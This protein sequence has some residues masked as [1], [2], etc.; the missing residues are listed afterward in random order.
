[1]WN[2]G[3]SGSIGP[4]LRPEAAASLPPGTGIGDYGEIVIGQDL[5]FAWHRFQLWAEVF[6]S[7]F[8][9]PNVGD[10]DLL[11]YYVEAKYKLTSQLFFAARWNQQLYGSVPDDEKEVQWGNNAARIDAVVGYRFSRYLQLKFQYSFTHF[12]EDVRECEHLV[13][14]QLTLKF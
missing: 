5:S 10:A 7:R 1:M 12:N 8:E 13:A 4:Y 14:S 2:F 6:E 9:V 11:S 3:I